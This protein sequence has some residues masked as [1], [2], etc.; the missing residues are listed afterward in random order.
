VQAHYGLS[1]G[2]CLLILV[3]VGVF[4]G[5]TAIGGVARAL[6]P[7]PDPMAGGT[8]VLIG[9]LTLA[10]ALA[11]WCLAGWPAA[12]SGGLVVGLALVAVHRPIRARWLPMRGRFSD[13][14]REWWGST[15]R[16]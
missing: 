14:L 13:G 7:G 4:L 5:G 3:P 16:R 2:Q 10:A 8:E 6:L 15:F 11:L 1:T 9:A 12:V